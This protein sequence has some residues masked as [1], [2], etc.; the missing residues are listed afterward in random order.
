MRWAQTRNILGSYGL[1]FYK[2]H[3]R[4]HCISEKKD[5][6][7]FS[8][9]VFQYCQNFLF[10]GVERGGNFIWINMPKTT[11]IPCFT[12]VLS[13]ICNKKKVVCVHKHA[14]CSPVCVENV[15]KWSGATG[16]GNQI[17][18]RMLSLIAPSIITCKKH[19]RRISSTLQIR[20]T[21]IMV[22]SYLFYLA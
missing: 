17:N 15:L 5:H 10:W 2:S 16:A 8:P 14:N 22:S 11:L 7:Y 20:V 3:R 12:S 1:Q 4:N 21:A 13:V 18:N 6:Y 9:L 19:C